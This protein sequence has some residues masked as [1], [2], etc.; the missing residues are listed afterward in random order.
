M[1]R[2]EY[3]EQEINKM[4]MNFVGEKFNTKFKYIATDGNGGTYK[5]TI[6]AMTFKHAAMYLQ[7]TYHS[8]ISLERVYPKRKIKT[9]ANK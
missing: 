4:H 3:L 5:D 8:V 9:P 7:V 1:T 2:E 6:K